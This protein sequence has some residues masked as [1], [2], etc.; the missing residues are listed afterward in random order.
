MTLLSELHSGH[1]LDRPANVTCS[2]EM[3]S[4]LSENNDRRISWCLCRWKI[5]RS[6]WL[7]DPKKRSKFSDLASNLCNLLD[8][9]SSYLRL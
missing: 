8:S 2:N 1:R 3:Y 9:D 5:M 7:V 4:K 6:C